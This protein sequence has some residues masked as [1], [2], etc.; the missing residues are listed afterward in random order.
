MS[1]NKDLVEKIVAIYNWILQYMGEKLAR[2]F[3]AAAAIELGNGAIT[4][5]SEATGVARST[6]RHGINDLKAGSEGKLPMELMDHDRRGGGGRTA[7]EKKFPTFKDSLKE[8]LEGYTYGTPMNVLLYTTQSERKIAS[9]L[10]DDYGLDVSYSTVGRE[11]KNLG[12]SRHQNQKA[13]QVGEDHPDRDAQFQ[14]INS[15]AKEFLD[16]GQPVISVDA[17]KKEN[18]GNFKNPGSEYRRTGDPRQVLDHDFLN[19]KLGQVTPY[20]VYVLND[21]TGFV[22]LGTDHDTA[23]FAGTSIIRWWETVGKSTFPDA[24]K[25]F[26]TADGGGSNGYRVHMWKYQMQLLANYSGLEVHISHYPR[27]ASK[28]NRIEH[29]LFCYITQN[30]QGQPLVDIK[31]VV[32][33][34]SSTTTTTGLKVQCVVDAN[35]YELHQQV[36]DEDMDSINLEPCEQF[37]TWNYVIKPQS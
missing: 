23:E 37:G 12:Y 18:L 28:W 26:I 35:R 3:L 27:G 34:I 17:K 7:Y 25:I 20:G 6:I 30:W 9:I 33:L 21:N 13:Q 11:L 4:W 19:K 29:R 15:K 10:K 36:S 24:K 32:N 22:N 31:T 5:L 8:I 1:T 14:F 2:F 16:E